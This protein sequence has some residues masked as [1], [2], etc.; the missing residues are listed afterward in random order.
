MRA[1]IGIRAHE[2]ARAPRERADPADRRRALAVA[3]EPERAIRFAEDAGRRQVRHEAG[4]DADGAGPRAAAAVRRAERLVG[5]GGDHGAAGLTGPEPA[6]DRVEVRAVHVREGPR[7][8]GRLQQLAD[9]LL[10]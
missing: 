10:E 9:A 5:V 8:V 7:L 3:L 1:Q 4:P 2:D 6:E